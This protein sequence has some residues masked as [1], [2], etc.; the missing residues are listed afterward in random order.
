MV[1]SVRGVC[2]PPRFT[3]FLLYHI[4]TVSLLAQN[5]ITHLLLLTAGTNCEKWQTF[6]FSSLLSLGLNEGGAHLGIIYEVT[7]PEGTACGTRCAALQY[8]GGSWSDQSA[9]LKIAAVLVFI[10]LITNSSG[11]SKWA[12]S[13]V[14]HTQVLEFRLRDMFAFWA[15]VE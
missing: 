10:G 12:S 15:P 8:C 7:E 1:W 3:F 2:C 11:F 14:N 6:Y 13:R 5:S 4:H 9:T